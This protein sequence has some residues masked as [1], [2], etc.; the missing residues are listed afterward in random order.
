MKMT[1]SEWQNLNDNYDTTALL[2]AVEH[3]DEA[4]RHLSDGEFCKP[5]Q[6]RD[7]LLKLHQLA[8]DVVNHGNTENASE[9]F[10]MASDLEMQVSDLI[11]SLEAIQETL[12]KLTELYP[13]SLATA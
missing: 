6:I 9:M 4:R 2:D 13:E 8:M 3:V 5:P 11:E 1:D 10:N 7:D 12:G